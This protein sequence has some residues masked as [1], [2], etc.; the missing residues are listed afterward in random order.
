MKH[1]RK[2]WLGVSLLAAG[3]AQPGE[4]MTG[5]PGDFGNV[6]SHILAGEGG[7]AGIGVGKLVHGQVSVPALNGAQITRSLSGNTLRRDH[8]FALHFAAN[9]TFNGWEIVWSTVDKAKCTADDEDDYELEE[10]VCWHAAN[11][12]I[13]KGKWSVK[14]DRLCTEPALG[15]AAEGAPCVSIVF[16][17]DSVAM[18]K[19]DGSMIGKAFEIV[20]DKR[21]EEVRARD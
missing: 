2:V 9:G 21:L 1:R 13:P 15:R 10:G 18:F 16:M 3:A 6:L 7:E 17:L 12:K 5:V 14:D 4:K 19:P 11:V 8:D 20:P